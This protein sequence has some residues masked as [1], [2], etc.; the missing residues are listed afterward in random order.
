M[1]LEI[2]PAID[3]RGGQV[4]NLVQGDYDRETVFGSDAG[5]T[6]ERFCA[7]G[8][9]R[10]H[11]VDLDGARDGSAANEPALH[12][13]V[14]AAG[15]VPVQ[16]G[17]GVRSLERIEA[18]LSLGVDRVILGTAV[19]EDPDL[20]RTAAVR[21]PSRVIL[22]LDARDGKLAV[23]GWLETADVSVDAAI[24]LFDALPLG[25]VLHTDIQRD[26]MLRGP[27]VQPTARLAG[28]TR[29]PVIASGGVSSVDD[30]LELARTRVIAGAIVGRALYTGAV[31][32]KQA[33]QQVAAC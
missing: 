31:D 10:I 6:A 25:A 30:L 12:D 23:R 15:D 33:L 28:L 4:V 3:L 11:V 29:H 13:I 9:S 19:L 14:A 24:A 20:V 22:G 7:Q 21:F 2:I 1:S 8:A 18:L 26:G 5:G 32:L 27:A 17:G 16:L